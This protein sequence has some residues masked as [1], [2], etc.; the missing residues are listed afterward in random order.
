[1][2]TS[3]D[4]TRGE[5]SESHAIVRAAGREEERNRILAEIRQEM[6]ES[7]IP[8]NAGAWIAVKDCLDR[9]VRRIHKHH[10]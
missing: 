10:E 7:P 1:M 8:E 2:I 3:Y 6:L 9:I 4:Q 5:L